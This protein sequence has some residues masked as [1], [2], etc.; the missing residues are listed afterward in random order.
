MLGET[1]KN[2]DSYW[3]HRLFELGAQCDIGKLVDAWTAVAARTEALRVVFAPSA[4][5]SAQVERA[6]EDYIPWV[7][8]TL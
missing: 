2:P 5:F 8:R 4:T 6:D 1:N 3:S 7:I